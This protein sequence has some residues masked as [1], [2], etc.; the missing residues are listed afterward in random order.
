MKALPALMFLLTTAFGTAQAVSW[1]DCCCGSFCEHK[2]TCTGC[3]PEDHCRGRAG[4]ASCC[5]PEQ[6][7]PKACSHLEPSS[8]IVT[9]SA[10][11]PDLSPAIVERVWS[12]DAVLPAPPP[13]PPPAIVDTGPPRILHLDLSVLR[14]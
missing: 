9:G 11:G 12:I 5:D 10:E 3:G 1:A 4:S 8:E 13:C 7:A 6:S 14:I 2:N